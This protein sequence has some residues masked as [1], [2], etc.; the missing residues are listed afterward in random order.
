MKRWAVLMVVA[1][2][3]IGLLTVTG[4]AKKDNAERGWLGVYTQSVT[5]DVA[6]AWDLDLKY[7]ALVNDVI[8][9]SPADKA[10][11]K[12]GDVIVSLN[13]EKVTD[14]DDLTD[15]IAETKPGDKASVGIVRDGEDQTIEV[16]L[17][18]PK[19]EDF[20][21]SGNWS[22][23]D[24]DYGSWT[25]KR[26][27]SPYIGVMLD[28]L[29][30][31][32]GKY[33]GA[34]DGEGALITEVVE[35]SP[36]EKAGLAAG[37]V[38]VKIDDEKV[39]DAGDVSDMIQDHS[40]G[41]KVAVTVLRDHKQKNIEVEVG[42]SDSPTFGSYRFFPG[43]DMPAINIP[44]L[45]G[46]YLGNFTDGD[47]AEVF[48]NEEFRENMKE[49]AEELKNLKLEVKSNVQVDKD[50]LKTEMDQL[51]KEIEQMKKELKR[52]LETMKQNRD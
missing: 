19:D 14:A 15:L 51:R 52:E 5:Y 37:D 43:P 4:F 9:D 44:K 24:H 38:I 27:K 36:A 22:K 20:I 1:I 26:E 40:K 10:G 35:D 39:E 25:V 11:L 21:W 8:G 18:E 3:A 33:F 45:K 49:L 42:E 12:E 41:D 7:G 28:N 2:L 13:G 47:D 17:G 29:T 50:E 30:D 46:L 23:G 32:L 16:T 34:A 6:K 31:Q 48:D